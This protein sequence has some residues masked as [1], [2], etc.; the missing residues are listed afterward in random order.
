MCVLHRKIIFDL[1]LSKC[2]MNLNLAASLYVFTELDT[3]YF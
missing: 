1:G 3:I 2:L